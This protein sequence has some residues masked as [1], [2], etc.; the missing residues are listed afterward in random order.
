M[1][2][3]KVVLSDPKERK[4][5]Q[6]EVEQKAS[7]LMGKKIGD[8]V[9]GGGLGLA[10]YKIELTGGSDTSGFPMR[11]DVDGAAKKNILL[12]GPP[13]FWPAHDG[14]RK[15]KSVRGNVVSEAVSQINAKVISAGAK[16]IAESW[17]IK[18]KEK[19]A[20]PEAKPTEKAAGEKPA[21]N[22]ETT[23]EKKAAVEK[24]AEKAAV[25]AEGKSVEEKKE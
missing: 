7:G 13:G 1:A 4:A 3:F 20:A 16:G 25:P 14:M 19:E 15:R 24:P 10:G 5:Y 9:D 17:N 23:T 11:R 12:A 2:N 22:G 6:K 21:A 8:M 18:A